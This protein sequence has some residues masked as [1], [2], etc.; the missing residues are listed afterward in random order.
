MPVDEAPFL[1]RWARRKALARTGQPLPEP[2]PTAPSTVLTPEPAPEVQV[3]T[4]P[5]AAPG[6]A[7]PA[8]ESPE[9]PPA[10]T[11][12]DVAELTRDSD[13]TGFVAQGVAPEVKNAAL[14]KL[15]SDP[16]F[17]VMD[18]LDI[19]IDDYG[20]PDPLPAGMLRKMVQSKLLGL[21]DEEDKADAAA[22]A[23]A[24]QETDAA[25]TL[26]PPAAPAETTPEN[27]AALAEPAEPQAPPPNT[28]AHEDPAMQLQPDDDAGRAG[29]APGAEQNPGRQH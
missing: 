16:H 2:E 27:P 13:Y 24:A 6:A 8:P 7:T 10:L 29:P 20:K 21:F 22:A 19:Y 28:A 9:P 23:L 18:G 5:Q 17:N 12:A 1:S 25:V 14:R 11:L 3:A 4:A 26:T 15:F